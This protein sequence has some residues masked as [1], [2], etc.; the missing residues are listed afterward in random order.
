MRKAVRLFAAGA[1]IM[2]ALFSRVSTSADTPFLSIDDVRVGTHG[3]ALTVLR[4]TEIQSFGVEVIGRVEGV[5]PVKSLILIRAYGTALSE[6]K[7]IASGMSGSPVYIGGKLLGAISYTFSN[8]DPHYGLVTPIKDMLRLWEYDNR[9][10][11]FRSST[12]IHIENRS[13]DGVAFGPAPQHGGNWLQAARA[14]TPIYV[15]GFGQRTLSKLSNALKPF[16]TLMP[17]QAGQGAP[18]ALSQAALRPG[19]ALGVQLVR[20]DVEA[21]AIGTVTWVQGDRLLAF[22]HPFMNLGEVGYVA[23]QAYVSRTVYSPSVPFKVAATT[24]PVGAIMQDRTAGISGRLGALPALLPIEVN[25]TDRDSGNRTVLKA[26]AVLDGNM[27]PLLAASI[28]MEALDRCLD[29]IGSGTAQLSFTVET[30]DHRAD[31]LRSNLFYSRDDIAAAS[32][33]ELASYLDFLFNNDFAAIRPVR[34][35]VDAVTGHKPLTAVVASVRPSKE[36]VRPG[37]TLDLVITLRPFR[38]ENIQVTVPVTLPEDVAAGRL[39]FFVRGGARRG[40]NSD[41]DTDETFTRG[42][43][44]LDE[45]LKQWAELTHNNDLVIQYVPVISAVKDETA[46]DGGEK[47][48]IGREPVIIIKGCDFVIQ[49]S[50]TISVEVVAG[51]EG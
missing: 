42:A 6:S 26:E 5:G 50:Q 34:V 49:G 12:P 4:G 20:G 17:A 14:Q 37:E 8:A 23:T 1:V 48:P 43:A 40:D 27:A 41:D 46:G 30:Q 7:G 44:T 51:T 2:L 32:A 18:A 24:E 15:R 31:L 25:V 3:K 45:A 11:A 9:Q 33:L 28:T 21:S 39:D 22:G 19:S 35:K 38:G 29:R 16:G 47:E 36:K 10:A 13:F